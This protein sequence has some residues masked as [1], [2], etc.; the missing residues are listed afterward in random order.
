MRLLGKIRH[1]GHPC[2]AHPC[3]ATDDTFASTLLYAREMDREGEKEEGRKGRG[4]EGS[5]LGQTAGMRAS[6]SLLSSLS[7]LPSRAHILLYPLTELTGRNG[8]PLLD[9]QLGVVRRGAAWCGVARRGV[10][11]TCTH[12]APTDPH[13]LH[14][15]SAYERR[16]SARPSGRNILP[17]AMSRAIYVRLCRC[18]R[19]CAH[20]RFCDTGG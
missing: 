17:R 6:S 2:R 19:E 4:K 16:V 12:I 7:R 20:V 13:E 1:T 18:A 9:V 8:V 14:I 11:R 3:R 15:S 10:A 5:R